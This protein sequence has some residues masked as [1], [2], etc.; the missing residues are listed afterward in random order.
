MLGLVT[1]GKVVIGAALIVYVAR[2]CR[3]PSG[4]LGR[5]LARRMNAS[6]DALT[7]WGLSHLANGSRA[8][9]LDVG[10]GG[11][12]TIETLLSR[13]TE[14]RV[15]GVDYSPA[16]VA[17]A[18]ERNRSS[19]ERG[20]VQIHEGSVSSL[21]FPDETFCLVTAVETHYYWP[22][23]N[24]DMREVM[25]VLKS[26]GAFM[27]I[28]ETYR[29]RRNDWLYRPVMRGVLRANYLTPEAHRRLLSDAGYRDVEVFEE[30]ARGWI[31]AVG[32]K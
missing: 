9:V 32:Y 19:I 13:A 26:G 14:G 25:R 21:P 22:D 2:Q 31:C 20:R 8:N 11:G 23:L 16:S 15:F 7:R 27:I 29:G 28:A 1:L 5:V 4:A 24:T 18:R 10:C 30:K 17:V 3:K 6:H 12:R